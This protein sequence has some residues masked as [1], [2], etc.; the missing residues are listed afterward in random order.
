V[1]VCQKRV[2][3]SSLASVSKTKILETFLL[4]CVSE[5]LYVLVF[6]SNILLTELKLFGYIFAAIYSKLSTVS[7]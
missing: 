2:I 4:L 1:V 5:V 7:T 3:K 6:V